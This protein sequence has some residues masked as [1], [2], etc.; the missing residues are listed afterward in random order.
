MIADTATATDGRRRR[1]QESRGKI[2]AAMVGLVADGKISPGAEDI[3]GRAGVGLR[4]VF[5]HFRDM[6]SLY[7]E[8]SVQ[9]ARDYVLVLKPFTATDWR[10]QLG[11]VIDR[12]ID[13][14]ERILP[15]K[16]AAD[17]HRHESPTIEA[18][19]ARFRDLLRA[20]LESTI[21][22]GLGGDRLAM[23]ALDLLLSPDTWL[24]LRVEQRLD[25]AL[26]RAVVERQ[27]ALIL[28]GQ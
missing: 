17:A 14:F 18:E 6:E 1:S 9:L 4:S 16:R 5:R 12:R 21:G 15:F 24:R 26:A 27:V 10:G 7:R 23:E 20:R 3:A 22:D 28:G 11:E 13:I 2:V 8:L 25:P 19:H